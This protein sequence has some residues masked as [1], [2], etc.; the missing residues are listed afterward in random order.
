MKFWHIVTFAVLLI[1]IGCV[2]QDDQNTGDSKY[3]FFAYD[4]AAVL[5]KMEDP[6]IV[7][8]IL[9]CTYDYSTPTKEHLLD[10]IS[11]VTVIDV[12]HGQLK[13]GD[14]IKVKLYAEG[15][16]TSEDA[17]GALY[18]YC[19]SKDVGGIPSDET[20][21]T[22]DWTD[23]AEYAKYGD[24]IANVLRNVHKWKWHFTWS[25]SKRASTVA[26]ANGKIESELSADDISAIANA[27]D[28]TTTTNETDLYSVAIKFNV[29][30]S[31]L[32][33]V[34]Q[35]ESIE[36]VPGQIIKLPVYKQP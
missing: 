6:S 15:G 25:A 29:S 12:F 35:L 14:K 3:G 18:Y 11:S 5:K 27:I 1:S 23:S 4:D 9:G 28:Y 21:F 10:F 33:K 26:T 34:N 20:A 2:S 31:I 30:P 36:L 17:K 32:R 19:L 8:I 22:C 13:R 24:S 7:G 16:P